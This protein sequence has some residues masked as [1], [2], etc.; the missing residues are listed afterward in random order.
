MG[1]Q[2]QYW[3][4]FANHPRCN[5]ICVADEQGIPEAVETKNRELAEQIGVPY[6]DDLDQA[7]VSADVDV[8]VVCVEIERRGP[9]AA[10]CAI[11]GKHLFLDKPSAGTVEDAYLIAEAVEE[12]GVKSQ[13]MSHNNSGLGVAA[14][15]AMIEH[16]VGK[17]IAIHGDCFMAKADVGEMPKGLVRK[18]HEQSTELFEPSIPNTKREMFT[19]AIYP[20]VLINQLLKPT[21]KKIYGMTSNYFSPSHVR[22]DSED[23]GGVMLETENGITATAFASRMPK[24]GHPLGGWSRIALVGTDRVLVFEERPHLEVFSYP[25]KD[26]S[27]VPVNNPDRSDNYLR[28]VTEFLRCIDEDNEPEVNARAAAQSVEIL[29]AGYISAARRKPLNL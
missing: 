14:K 6:V 18:E 2:S 29:L 20:M 10:K 24:E 27:W 23:F 19:H 7:L 13:M 15:R 22:V 1:H 11:A 5:I 3:P 26:I 28:D 25:D 4:K 17:I 9:I 16:K 12:T 8:A 21:V